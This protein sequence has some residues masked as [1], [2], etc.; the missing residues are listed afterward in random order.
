MFNSSNPVFGKNIFANTARDFTGTNT[1]TVKGTM[2]KAMLM[3]A[4]VILG[5][6]YTWK[7]AYGLETAN[8]AMGWMVGGA[9]GGLITGLIIAFIPKTAGW[10]SPIYSILQGL[11]LG[12]ISAFFEARFHGIVMNAVG[13]TLATAFLLFFIY[14]TGIIKVTDKLR[15]GIVAATGAI[16]LFYLVTWIVS[17]F[18]GNV[19]FMMNSSLLSIGISVVIVIVASMN[20][21]LDFDFIVKGEQAGAPKYMEWY[22]AF[23]LMVTLIWLYLE[24]LKLLAKLSRR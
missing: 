10:L 8:A 9:I 11:F 12:A 17:M 16:A 1:M 14:R 2:G 21:L 23:G 22:G 4:M 20:L 3:L 6:S 5:A 13:L 18:G 15:T 24:M 19:G 7:M